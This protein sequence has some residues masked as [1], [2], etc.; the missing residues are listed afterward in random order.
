MAKSA[1]TQAAP[2]KASAAKPAVKSPAPSAAHAGTGFA[3][4][5][6]PQ[7]PGLNQHRLA[8]MQHQGGNQAVVHG[9]ASGSIRT[10][11]PVGAIDSPQ[12]QD[13]E[14]VAGLLAASMPSHV[15]DT[16]SGD[17]HTLSRPARTF[18]EPRLGTVLDGVH[19][20]TG[21]RAAEAAGA[22]DAN[23]FTVGRDIVFGEGKFEPGTT[24]GSRILAHELA[25]VAQQH[26]Q[27]PL[28]QRDPDKKKKKQQTKPKPRDPAFG[29]AYKSTT[30]NADVPYQEYKDAIGVNPLTP[31]IKAAHEYQ[32]GTPI[33]PVAI[34]IEELRA[35]LTP[36]YTPPPDLEKEVEANKE[37]IESFLGMLRRAGVEIT[38]E[39]VK[40]FVKPRRKTPEQEFDEKLQTYLDPINAA[41]E[42]MG[43]DTAEAQAVYFA[44]AAG[45]TGGLAKLEEKTIRKKNY[46]DFEGR[47]PIQVTGKGNYVQTLAYL[48]RQAEALKNSKDPKKVQQGEA[49]AKAV[50]AIKKDPKA[51]ANPQFTF[52]FSA[53]FMQMI[54][55]VRQSADI[56][57]NASFP[58][59]SAEDRW[60]SGH[61]HQAE[62]DA[63]K[64]RLTKATDAAKDADSKTEKGKKLIEDKETAA[65]DVQEWTSTV[66]RSKIKADTYQRALGIL[67][68]KASKKPTAASASAAAGEQK[69]P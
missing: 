44:H 4:A 22:L 38:L 15:I 26:G 58:G 12:E 42:T 45:E 60:V 51:A 59:N 68:K 36:K 62:L 53:A 39:Q 32:G 24:E 9:L 35:I 66:E 37:T 11:F 1:P 67:K 31:E 47:G 30:S 65:K 69:E 27:E 20:H 28:I 23:A 40:E 48:E 5:L 8:E 46:K 17:D 18:L 34:S 41:F 52:L 61:N 13:A 25:H 43:I 57:P 7:N 64:A 16:A 54:G 55:G 19:L 29:P 10:S 56:K 49:A 3:L 50:A 2:Q 21:S 63:A 14:R 33:D 6:P